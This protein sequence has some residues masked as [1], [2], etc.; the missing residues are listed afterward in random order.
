MHR[1]RSR[2]AIALCLLLGSALAA[3]GS[4]GGSDA[5]STQSSTSSSTSSSSTSSSSETTTTEAV[6]PQGQSALQ[7]TGPV[8]INIS[9]PGG[10]CNY[11]IPA[12]QQGLVYTV[13]SRDFPG[14]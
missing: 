7:A 4:S 5:A 6:T 13:S 2:F 14:S 10:S 11:F 3:C 12:Q 8:T 1:T 9:G